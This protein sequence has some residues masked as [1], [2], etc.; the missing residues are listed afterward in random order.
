M[1]HLEEA[2]SEYE[3][4]NI[5]FITDFEKMVFKH[6]YQL[7]YEEGKKDGIKEGFVEGVKK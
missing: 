2:M 1:N 5:F 4:N 3:K 7:G 6:A